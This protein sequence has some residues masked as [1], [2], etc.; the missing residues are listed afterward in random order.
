MSDY[1]VPTDPADPETAGYE[2]IVKLPTEI[3]AEPGVILHPLIEVLQDYTGLLGAQDAFA[4]MEWQDVRQVA[5]AVSFDI[6]Q[7]DNPGEFLRSRAKNVLAG[8]DNMPWR[9]RTRVARALS[10]AAD[11]CGQPSHPD[12]TVTP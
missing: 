7:R 4:G 12:G 1:T 6:T 2:L 11:L 5:A 8:S 10:I 9:D 3:M